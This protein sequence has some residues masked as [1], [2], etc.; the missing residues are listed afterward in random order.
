MNDFS[1]KASIAERMDSAYEYYCSR[2]GAGPIGNM[3]NQLRL[4]E[5]ER[6]AAGCGESAV[7]LMGDWRQVLRQ[8]PQLKKVRAVTCNQHAVH[9]LYESIVT[10]RSSVI[11]G[12]S[13]IKKSICA[14]C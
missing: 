12:L 2:Y 11:W 4:S 14:C 3:E 8:L 7:R 5:A 13:T 1:K 10:L 9:E 6:V